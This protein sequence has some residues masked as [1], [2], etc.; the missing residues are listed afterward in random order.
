MTQIEL[1]NWYGLQ[2]SVAGRFSGSG[3]EKTLRMSDSS[4]AY[5]ETSGLTIAPSGSSNG[6]TIVLLRSCISGRSQPRRRSGM[7]LRQGARVLKL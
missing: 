5:I 3:F 2:S 4:R 1:D 7:E 6:V